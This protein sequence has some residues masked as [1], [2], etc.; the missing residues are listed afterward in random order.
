[1]KASLSK[2]SLLICYLVIAYVAFFFY[3]K[4][5]KEKTEATISWDVSGYYWYLPSAFIYKDVKKFDFK[6]YILYKYYPTPDF[7]QA[8]MHEASGNY[9]IK[10]ASGLA[11]T[12][13]PWFC[14]GH[15]W[16]YLSPSY[17]ADGFSFAYQISIG[18]GMLI[19]TFIGL[20]FLRKILL[21][22][23]SDH[24]TA[25]VILFL[26]IGTNY[27]N[28][29]AIDQAMT[30]SPLFTIYALIIWFSIRYYENPNLKSI[31]SLGLLCGLATL[32]RPTE[33]ISLSIPFLWGI[34]NFSS[35]KE[36]IQY[37]L[38]SYRY[39]LFFGFAFLIVVSI[40]LFYWKF[41]TGEWVVYSYKEQGFS[42][43]HPHWY[44]YTLSYRSGWLRY[45]PLMTLPFLGL[46][47]L[48]KYSCKSYIVPVF[49]FLS[50]YITSAWDVWDYGGTAGR[51]MVQY[52]PMLALPFAALSSEAMK[53]RWWR[54][55]LTM[56]VFVLSYISIW[57]VVNAH[58][59]KVTVIEASKAYYW[60]MLGKWS[61]TDEDL[62][63]LD[64][65]DVYRKPM[66]ISTVLYENDFSKD[67]S[68]NA[69]V[70][71]NNAKI[72]LDAKR[73]L[74]NRYEIP[75]S[76]DASWIRASAAFKC[77][78]REWDLWQQAQFIIKFYNEGQE[79]KTNAIRIYRILKDG[80]SKTIH[81]DA[82]CPSTYD[83]VT[84]HFDNMG[85]DL[86]LIIDDL[87][88]IAI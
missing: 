58:T 5:Q 21:K 60:H 37:W 8:S 25:F 31:L 73:Q 49:I 4:W 78:A 53:S 10:Y 46:F 56:I 74:S 70:E 12:M 61:S 15:S 67:T 29:A 39:L 66:Q 17:A 2:V 68:T 77:G 57:W 3:P 43:L 42:W 27:L 28:Y 59:G 20:Y 41:V 40:Q 48:H 33:A 62:K 84:V 23:F 82:K 81:I 51:A 6:H 69:T 26:V 35:L 36:R 87:K 30:H 7:Q 55:L 24:V 88:V 9:V 83:R 16:A 75:I 50:L 13:L 54:Y 72:L 80:E 52:Y 38:K 1:M 71:S 32:I 47:W 18:I 45:C 85:S 79:V 64:N 44:D 86:T 34:A 22:F 19:Y 63:L 76:K 65:Q 11:I 14:L